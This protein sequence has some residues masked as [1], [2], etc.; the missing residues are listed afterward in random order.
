MLPA[1]FCRAAGIAPGADL[2]AEV[3]AGRIVLAP[4]RPP[5]AERIVERAC[6]L[7]PDALDGL[8]DDLAAQHDHYLYATPKRPE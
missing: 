7:P 5:L 1:E 3:Q 2:V 6:T 4:A 8:P